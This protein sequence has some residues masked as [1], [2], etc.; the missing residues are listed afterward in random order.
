MKPSP[1]YVFTDFDGTITRRDLLYHLLDVAAPEDWRAI[2]DALTAE[3]LEEKSALQRE[4]DLLN[5]SLEEAIE[6]VLD[7]PIDPHFAP[8]ARFCQQH[9]IPLEILSGGFEQF[10]SAYLKKH[11]LDFIPFHSN[12]ARVENNRWQII[13]APNPKIRNLCNHCKTYWLH[14]KQQAGYVIVYIGD[15]N[16]DRCP[17][18]HAHYRF[19]KGDLARYLEKHDYPYIP[20]ENFADVLSKFQSIV[21]YHKENSRVAPIAHFTD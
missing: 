6:I 2:E 16:T 13:G 9:H 19:A 15:G 17:A 5:I 8:F 1:I 20:F 7:V 14:Q 12:R 4:F 18:T 11:Q 21:N 10:I 3:Q